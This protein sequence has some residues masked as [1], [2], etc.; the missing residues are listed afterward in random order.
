[1]MSPARPGKTPSR[2]GPWQA[3][4]FFYDKEE[5]YLMRVLA[6]CTIIS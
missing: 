1:M 6:E 4:L 3:C 2:H 5:D